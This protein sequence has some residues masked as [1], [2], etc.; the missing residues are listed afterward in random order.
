MSPLTTTP[1]SLFDLKDLPVLP[2]TLV[3]LLDACNNSE[4]NMND[5]GELVAQDVSLSARILQLANSAFIGARTTFTKIEQAVVYLGVDTIRNLAVSVSVYE[6]FNNSKNSCPIHLP[7]FWYHS[8][9]TAILTKKLAEATGYPNP[10][11]AYMAALLH[12]LGKFL[13]CSRFPEKYQQLLD[14]HPP[15][16]DFFKH[17]KKLFGLC[18]AKTGS[19]LTRSWK[20][21]DHIAHAIENH[22]VAPEPLVQKTTLV[23]LLYIANKLSNEL[24][25]TPDFSQYTNWVELPPDILSDSF[26]AAGELIDE[27]ATSMSMKIAPQPA[28]KP[29]VVEYQDAS[30]L[31]SR[32]ESITTMFGALDN[33]LKAHNSQRIV[34]VVEESLLIIYDIKNCFLALPENN[35]QKLHPQLSQHNPLKARI[36]H[37]TLNLQLFPTLSQ[38]VESYKSTT[39]S[40][41]GSCQTPQ[42]KSLL[43][44]LD[45]DN[46]L[47]IP[48]PVDEDTTGALLVCISHVKLSEIKSSSFDGL[49]LLA[50]QTGARLQL[51][52][53]KHHQAEEIS[54]K[55]MEAVDQMAQGIAH[56][57]SNPL[58]IIQT[59]LSTLQ[60]KV[61]NSGVICQEISII[62]SEIERI[63]TI[64]K[65]LENLTLQD[66]NQKVKTEHLQPL[67]Q[68]MITLF[69]QTLFKEKNIRVSVLLA[70]ETRELSVPSDVLRQ[71][72]TIL[73]KNGAEALNEGGRITL[74]SSLA[75]E[76]GAKGHKV[77]TLAVSDDGPG[78]SDELKNKIF[79]AGVSTKDQGHLGLGL[80]IARKLITDFGGSLNYK[81]KT[82]ERGAQFLLEIPVIK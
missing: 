52:K 18:H 48:V 67:I 39:I 27:I 64:A 55:Q 45:C 57:I 9:H 74:I 42:E 22:H 56:E 2:Q 63:N 51:E 66:Q 44:R 21:Q 54:K 58:S 81:D 72:L 30:K 12:D 73:M 71:I 14:Q 82:L 65:Q 49:T 46:I 13:L 38:A 69:G 25:E 79:T 35:P 40:L 75:A 70:P 68:E 50:T 4:I 17:E 8:L 43:N 20:L 59:Y 41:Q 34:Q 11:E 10:A 15:Y 26:E 78:I 60:S 24:P 80:T 61:Q 28:Q 77:L 5:I 47:C 32:V 6:T 53:L 37:L 7:Y 33:L 36:S 76:T 1:D 19:F 16:G 3:K 62:T 23:D 31:D 29:V